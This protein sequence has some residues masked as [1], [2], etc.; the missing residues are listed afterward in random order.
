MTLRR[1]DANDPNLYIWWA[2]Q[3]FMENL[4]KLMIS[5]SLWNLSYV[6]THETD[7]TV[8]SCSSFP[9][10]LVNT[11][12]PSWSL[13]HFASKFRQR[14]IQR[15]SGGGGHSLLSKTDAAL[16]ICDDSRSGN[17][18]LG[19]HPFDLSWGKQVV[20]SGVWRGLRC[21]Q[22]WVFFS[23]RAAGKLVNAFSSHRWMR[24]WQG[25]QA[26]H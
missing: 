5:S 16:L 9:P 21:V 14:Q 2:L 22:F 15:E 4:L 3:S 1:L 13:S 10:Q 6:S 8:I 12:V 23:A 11:E 20:I 24:W 7:H 26:L 17:C 18:F 19:F 25:V